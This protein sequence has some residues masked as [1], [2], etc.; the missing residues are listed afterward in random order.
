MENKKAEVFISYHTNSSKD[1]TEKICA[2]LEGAGISCW[3]AP[4]NV[5]GPYAKSIVD[6]IEGCKVFLLILNQQSSDS[7]HVLNEINTAFDRLSKNEEITILPFK[8]EECKLSKDAYYYLGR[9]HMMDGILPPEMKRIRELI[10]RIKSILG[11]KE[12]LIKKIDSNENNTGREYGLTSS[13]IYPD[14]CFVGR[15]QELETIHNKMKNRNKLFL[16]GMGGIGKSEIA[17]TYCNIYKDKYDVI[18]WVSYTES[19]VKTISS[20]YSFAIKG[21]DRNNYPEDDDQNYYQRKLRILKEITNEKVLIVMD[22]FDVS[23]DPDLESFCSGNYSVLFTTR[24]QQANTQFEL[25]E[26]EAMQDAN[27]LM[28]VFRAEY[29]RNLDE[30]GEEYVHEILEILQGH[31]L[32]IRLVASA[33]QSRRISPEKMRELLKAG[34]SVME[35]KNAKAAELIFGRLKQVL[36]VSTLSEEELDVLKNLALLPMSGIEVETLFDWCQFDDFD[37]LDELVRKSWIILN[38]VTDEVHLHPLVSELMVEELENDFECCK[39]LIQAILEAR[40]HTIGTTWKY[41]L[42]LREVF[43]SVLQKLPKNHP[44][45]LNVAVNKT[46]IIFDM[47]EY[48]IDEVRALMNQTDDLTL[49]LQL[50]N[51]ISHAYCLTGEPE[52]GLE[53]ARRGLEMISIIPV[54]QLTNPQGASLINFNTRIAEASRSLGDLDTAEKHAEIGLKYS[55]KFYGTSPQT[56]MAWSKYHLA[57]ILYLKMNLGRSEQLMHEAITLFAE[58]KDTWSPAFCYELLGQIHM[59]KKQYDIA[60]QECKK[61]YDILLPQI[62]ENHKD[63][64]IALGFLGNV[65]RHSG[66][67]EKAM[68]CYNRAV[69]I[70]DR[71]N[72]NK[73]ANNMR[74]VIASGEIGY[75]S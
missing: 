1:T 8:T 2:A 73:M 47:S 15:N 13:S 22:N 75:L 9:I 11:T 34:S 49:K 17:K 55:G 25:V 27:E 24:M 68:G 23:D 69:D 14:K 4:R 31:P 5:Q 60:E 56:T 44:D 10:E 63:L 74:K 57:R 28:E 20:D 7:A 41:K 59:Q 66:E 53:E 54:E 35:E 45:R 67:E 43:V 39:N 70:L 48:G 21:I 33:M 37:V 38:P 12:E 30:A 6:A 26:I 16:V 64:A 42:W 46:Y 3:Y 32:S 58:V 52:K 65:Y 19:L 50:Q 40:N 62:G 18:I 71:I 36:K 72:M 61:A 51:R 29:V